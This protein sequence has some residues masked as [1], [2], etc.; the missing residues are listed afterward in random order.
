MRGMQAFRFE[1]DPNGAQRVTLARHV[2]AARFAYN[3]GLA[4]CLEAIERGEPIP[5]AL[6]LHK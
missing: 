4:R 3:W 1:R 5:S 6:R 2:G